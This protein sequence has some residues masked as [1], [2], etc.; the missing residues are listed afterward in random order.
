MIVHPTRKR[1]SIPTLGLSLLVLLPCCGAIRANNGQSFPVPSVHGQSY[2]D[3]ARAS[4][5]HDIP[6]AP[7]GITV[8]GAPPYLPDQ[9]ITVQ[10]C[11]Q[12]VTYN[13]SCSG[14]FVHD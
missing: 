4:A 5:V 13:I 3:A 12:R 14:A 10:G 7:E 9:V 6:C 1:I 8:L 11:G 2:G